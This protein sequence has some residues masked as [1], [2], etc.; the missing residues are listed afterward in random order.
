VVCDVLNVDSANTVDDDD[1]RCHGNYVAGFRASSPVR[2][3]SCR[4]VA[5]VNGT[6][7]RH[8]AS[9]GRVALIKHACDVVAECPGVAQRRSEILRR[10]Q[11]RVIRHEVRRADVRFVLFQ[12][13]RRPVRRV[14]TAN[15]VMY[16]KY[17]T[18]LVRLISTRYFYSQ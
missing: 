1:G 11:H 2:K 13:D 8:D 14:T 6:A 9:T 17:S 16:G 10:L 12:L 15:I 7:A 4:E 5:E 3:H 18:S